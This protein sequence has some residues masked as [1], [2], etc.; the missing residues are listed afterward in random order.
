MKREDYEINLTSQYFEHFLKHDTKIHLKN[1]MFELTLLDKNHDSLHSV[2]L[3]Q[4]EGRWYIHDS[5]IFD[6]VT[7]GEIALCDFKYDLSCMIDIDLKDG[8]DEYFNKY[9]LRGYLCL[10]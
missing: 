1:D 6:D 9:R 5:N 2:V 8:H 4:N 3:Y 7:L 10:I